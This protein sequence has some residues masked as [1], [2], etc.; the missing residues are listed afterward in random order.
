MI[1]DSEYPNSGLALDVWLND[2][3]V[4]GPNSV[5]IM[6]CTGQ[7]D[8][9]GNDIYE[10]D[11]VKSWNLSEN[12]K[13][14]TFKP[15]L[16]LVVWNRNYYAIWRLNGQGGTG[17]HFTDDEFGVEVVGHIYEEQ[18]QMLNKIKNN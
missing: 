13:R 8:K 12:P 4:L 17:M 9:K 18:F 6:Q 14:E 11:V 10:H 16:C 3:Q 1:Y 15:A 2:L 5:H 7:K